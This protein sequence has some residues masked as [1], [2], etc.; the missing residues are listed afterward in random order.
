MKLSRAESGLTCSSP[1][2]TVSSKPTA[3][4]GLSSSSYGEAG[5]NPPGSTSI[6]EGEEV[7]KRAAVDVFP[8]RLVIARAVSQRRLID[9]G[10][11]KR[12]SQVKSASEEG[13]GEGDSY[14]SG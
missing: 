13:E 7:G 8:N 1:T 2:R 11:R 6:P 5:R 10:H 3:P 9:I 4:I 14:A 12:T